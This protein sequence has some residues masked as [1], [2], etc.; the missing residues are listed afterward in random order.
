MLRHPIPMERPPLPWLVRLN[1]HGF[2]GW[3]CRGGKVRPKRTA[4][5]P[6]SAA[7]TQQSIKE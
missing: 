5:A 1:R 6:R 2:A 4:L 3:W 7:H